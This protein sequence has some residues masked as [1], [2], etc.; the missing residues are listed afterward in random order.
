MKKRDLTTLALLGIGVGLAVGSCNPKEDSGNN[1]ASAEEQMSPDMES[2][3]KSL[4]SDAQQKFMQMDA[5]HRMMAVE[6]ANQSCSGKNKCAGM[7]G[8]S[9]ANH[10]CAGKNSCKGQGGTPIKDAN[11]AVEA[12]YQNQMSQR[13]QMQSG[14]GQSNAPNTSGMSQGTGGLGQGHSNSGSN[15]SNYGGANQPSSTYSSTN[16]ST[17]TPSGT[18]QS[19]YNSGSSQS[20][21][22]PN[23]S[24]PYNSSTNPSTTP[25]TGVYHGSN[26][27]FRQNY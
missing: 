24:Q 5:Q 13:E 25:N 26:Q 21:Y 23:Q 19:N 6:M 2:Y 7:G 12:Q 22:T 18:G 15:P 9:T 10:T 11:K 8:C 14:M 16:P 3:Y 17:S 4:S 27:P 20:H 1:K